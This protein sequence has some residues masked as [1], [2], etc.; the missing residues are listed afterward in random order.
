MMNSAPHSSLRRF[1]SAAPALA[2]AVVASAYLVGAAVFSVTSERV[3]Q[4]NMDAAV[5]GPVQSEVS[6][7]LVTQTLAY[8]SG[9]TGVAGALP[10]AETITDARIIAPRPVVSDSSGPRIALIIDDV[11]LDRDATLRVLS[12][13]AA[14]T[15]AVLPYSPAS[16]QTAQMAQAAGLDVLVHVPM[17]PLGLADPGPNALLVGLDDADL[18]ARIRWAMARVPGAVGLNNHMGSRFTRDPRAMRVALGAI[19]ATE[20]LFVDSRTTANSRGAAAARGLGLDVLERDIFLDH[21]INRATILAQLTAAEALSRRRGWAVIIGHPHD[22][23]L[24]TLESWLDGARERGIEF[25]TVT[26][27]AAQIEQDPV[28]LVQASLEQESLNQ[29]LLRQVSSVQ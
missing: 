20:P 29:E 23:T 25:V 17:E 9:G 16:T 13:D 6:A 7:D 3:H 24:E 8:A 21:E 27:L 19:A 5:S 18:Q 4:E 1:Q 10:T 22:E 28:N 12:L 26:Q 15:I 2:S 11:G 14:L